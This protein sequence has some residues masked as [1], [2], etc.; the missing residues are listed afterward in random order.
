M[1]IPTMNKQHILAQHC[2]NGNK[3]LHGTSQF[4]LYQTQISEH[5]SCLNCKSIKQMQEPF[6][7]IRRLEKRKTKFNDLS[8][9][10]I[11]AKTTLFQG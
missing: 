7:A 10:K 8:L 11:F 4:S 2:T 9:S 1:P 5:K 3:Q 6:L